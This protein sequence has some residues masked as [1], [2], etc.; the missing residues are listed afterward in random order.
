MTITIWFT[1]LKMSAERVLLVLGDARAA[2]VANL[3]WLGGSAAGLTIG[4]LLGGMT[5]FALGLGFGS[6]TSHLYVQYALR[7]HGIRIVRQDVLY[8]S[9]AVALALA[10]TAL[11]S[12]ALR[13]SEPHAS[14]FGTAAA[15]TVVLLGFL[16]VA[17]RRIFRAFANR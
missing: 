9:L 12:L 3:W 16:G 8:T 17:G 14:A 13:G 11:P 2:A 7:G 15:S 5:G 1:L 4:F 6:L 10:G